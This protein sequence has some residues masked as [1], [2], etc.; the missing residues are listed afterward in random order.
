MKDLSRPGSAVSRL[1]SSTCSIVLLAAMACTQVPNA[2]GEAPAF[3]LEAVDGSQ[4]GLA[5]YQG[6]LVLL[7]FWATWCAPCHAQ[8]EILLDIYPEYKDRGFEILSIDVEEPPDQVRSFVESKG[9]PY[10]VLLDETGEVS[11]GFDVLA[12]PTLVLVDGSGEM[13]YHHPGI[14]SE[15]TLRGLI[16]KHLPEASAEGT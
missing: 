3:R 5:D 2:G 11:L 15:N 12:L 10:P 13:V 7:D 9:Y 1:V 6:Q 8:A 16:E 14:T 4:I